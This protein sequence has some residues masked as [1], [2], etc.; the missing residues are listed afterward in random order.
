MGFVIW[1]RLQFRTDPADATPFLR[2][3]N[4]ALSG[5]LLIDAAID[6]NATLGPHPSTFEITLW[7]LPLDNAKDLAERARTRSGSD[8]PILV[9]IQLGYFD[10]PATRRA[11]VLV[12]AIT[13]T[14]NEV[15]ADGS[16]LTRIKGLELAGY[17]LRRQDY[18]YHK[19]GASSI[20]EIL[21]DLARKTKV[22]IAH[23]GVDGTARDLTIAAGT[24]LSA[25]GTLAAGAGVP[26]A[27]R[28][29]QAVL[30][31]G[32][33][34]APPARF[35]AEENIV[36]KRRWDS[37]SPDLQAPAGTTT[38]YELTVLG[39]PTLQIGGRADLEGSDSAEL[40][41]ESVRHLFSL[42]GGYRCE[43]TLLDA[44]AAHRPHAVD[45]AHAV[46]DD[47]QSLTRSLFA[48]H[49]AI[50]I[51]EVAAYNA[52]GSG[53]NGGHRATLDYGRRRSGSSVD[54]AVDDRLVLHDKPIA[55]V[56]AWD[57]TGLM[58]PVYPGMRALLLHNDGAVDDAI[59][60]GFLWSRRAE[61]RP[62]ANEPGDFWLCLPTEV[63]EGRPAGKGVNDL[64]DASGHRIVQAV[65]LSLEVGAAILPEVGAR[66]RPPTGETLIIQHAAG[67]TV[68]IAADGSVAVVT[69]GQDV[70][71][72][73]GRASITLSGGEI[74]M[75]ADTI[76]LAASSVE[77]G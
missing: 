73:N 37:G 20:D 68:S 74:T 49:P 23:E 28:A 24:A 72:G 64:T 56:F 10:Q 21:A 60:G 31:A 1:Y 40:R 59:T 18:P 5:D 42:R 32:R 51:G 66:P 35:R 54:D 22:G 48:D 16:L 44:D 25:L 47:F 71:L 11:T 9:Q 75:T 43:L 34:P 19:P 41:I 62:P 14:R 26:L 70:T 13:E 29:G 36:A 61:H 2:V 4:D 27:V 50:D 69:D 15:A 57:R 3:S 55:S 53:D 39:D 63:S 77:V 33:D 12:G 76:K 8:R 38:R 6:T 30:G 45:G 67:T 17:L 7:D 58:V 65:G 52:T 46:A